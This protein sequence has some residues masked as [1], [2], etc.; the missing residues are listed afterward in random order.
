VGN[1]V[2]IAADVYVAPGVTIGDNAVI[3][4]RS[5]VFDDMPPGMVCYGYPCKPIKSRRE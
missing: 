1:G 3:G 2:W 5:S 4:A